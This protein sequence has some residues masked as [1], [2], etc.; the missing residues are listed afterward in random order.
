[1]KINNRLF[2]AAIKAFYNIDA[3][4][5]NK[6]SMWTEMTRIN[7][8]LE[9][10]EYLEKLIYNSYEGTAVGQQQVSKPVKLFFRTNKSTCNEWFWRVRFSMINI[11]LRSDHYE[12]AIRHSYEYIQ[13]CLQHNL[14]SVSYLISA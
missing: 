6:N 7:L 2:L 13:Y 14:T 11:A 4:Q 10:V 9:F 12:I 5:I 1:M 3:L 8:L